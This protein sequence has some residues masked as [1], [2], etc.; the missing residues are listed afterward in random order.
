MFRPTFGTLVA[1]LLT[2]SLVQAADQTK[3]DTHSHMSTSSSTTS[4]GSKALHESMMKGMQEMS[5]MQMSGDA[6][7]DFASMMIAHHQQAIEMSRAQLKNGKD[8][9]V[10]KKAEE[11]IAASEKDIADLKSWSSRRQAGAK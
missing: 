7:R 6:D 2:A 3:S 4:S 9:Q 11:I 1:L 10:R 8:P 5:S